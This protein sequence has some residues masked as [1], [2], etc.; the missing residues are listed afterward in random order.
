M[1]VLFPS[2][3]APPPLFPALGLDH[4]GPLEHKTREREG[5]NIRKSLLALSRVVEALAR[6]PNDHIPYRDSKLTRAQWL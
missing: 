2:A 3:A 1:C 6:N 4:S 5:A